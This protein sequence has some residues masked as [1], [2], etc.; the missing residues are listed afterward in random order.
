[1]LQGKQLS[2]RVRHLSKLLRWLPAG[3]RGKARLARTVLGDGLDETDVTVMSREGNAFVVPNLRG[4][5]AFHL[6]TDGVY[7]IDEI[8][9]VLRHLPPG[10]VFA[11]VGAN[12]G[13]YTVPAAQKVGDAGRVLAFEA[14]PYIF[15]YLQRNVQLNGLKNTTLLNYA[16]S[17]CDNEQLAFYAAPTENFGMGTLTDLF[18][19]PPQYVPAFTL[20]YL[21]QQNEIEHIDVM[22]M[23]VEGHEASVFAGASKLLKGPTPPTIIF[24]FCDWAEEQAPGRQKGD[25][26]RILRDFG[27]DIWRLADF[28]ADQAPLNEVITDGFYSLVARRAD[29]NY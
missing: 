15:P 7:E 26:Q 9:F 13:A 10:S 19:T 6:L 17:N 24:E 12:I 27:Y 3:T 11:D 14:S 18:N 5:L 16:V 1:M 28:I 22:K 25:A 8:D 21:L 2:A 29:V 23:D 4:A 20:D